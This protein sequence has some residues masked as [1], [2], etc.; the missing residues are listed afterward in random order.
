MSK[1]H[2]L[3]LLS[4]FAIVVFLLIFVLLAEK[5][6]IG[7]DKFMGYDFKSNIFNFI[8]AIILIFNISLSF[9]SLINFIIEIYKNRILNIKSVF[10]GV[11]PV[12]LICFFSLFR[13]DIFI[14][15]ILSPFKIMFNI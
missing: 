1:L 2:K 15:Y 11:Y 9:L 12:I 13:L 8:F 10:L 5:N 14:K 3:T 7:F 6:Y 4:F